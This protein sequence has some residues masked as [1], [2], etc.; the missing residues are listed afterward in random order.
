MAEIV[1][2]LGFWD[3]IS[4]SLDF[5]TLLVMF[6]APQ[7]TALNAPKDYEYPIPLFVTA[8][9]FVHGGCLPHVHDSQLSDTYRDVSVSSEQLPYCSLEFW[10]NRDLRALVRLNAF[11][12][13][14]CYL[15]R[16]KHT[17]QVLPIH[18]VNWSTYERGFSELVKTQLG[19][20]M[21]RVEAIE[22]QSI[23]EHVALW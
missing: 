20:D 12:Y 8:E 7:G 15:M 9:R 6:V 18:K 19:L 10:F 11:Y 5:E 21:Y 22:F 13:I 14:R 4:L 23:D 1:S 16:W 17:T 2:R 3:V